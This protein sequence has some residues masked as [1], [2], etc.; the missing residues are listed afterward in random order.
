MYSRSPAGGADQGDAADDRRRAVLLDAGSRLRASTPARDARSGT[1]S[2]PSTG[3]TISA[4]AAW[5]ARRHAVLR[6]ARTAISSRSNMKDGTK[7]L[8]QGD[9]RHEPVLLRLGRRRSSS[10]ITLIAGV[11]GDDMDNPGYLAGP[12]S[13]DRRDA[14]ALVHRAAEEGRP[15]I[16]HLAERRD[17]EARRRH[18]VAAGHLRSRAESR[19]S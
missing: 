7:Q 6:D 17:D 3:G 12:R 1:T 18:D 5:R 8:G 14:V 9:L 15:R 13:G 16:G 19:S 11:S 4:T 2:W 10:R